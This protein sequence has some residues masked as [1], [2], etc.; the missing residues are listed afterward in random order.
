MEPV[1]GEGGGG[2][3]GVHMPCQRV[4]PRLLVPSASRALIVTENL[5][6][7]TLSLH[8]RPC[9]PEAA[10]RTETEFFTS[11]YVFKCSLC[12]ISSHWA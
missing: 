11:V 3:V 10:A 12:G 9:G 6:T 7:T 8:I 1:A 5:Q 4:L 2:I